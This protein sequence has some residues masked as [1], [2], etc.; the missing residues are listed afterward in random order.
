MGSG[1]F[2]PGVKHPDLEDC[3]PLTSPSEVVLSL[4]SAS[5]QPQLPAV[6]SQLDEPEELLLSACLV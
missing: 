3:L 1:V 5:V 6:G 4:R 2:A